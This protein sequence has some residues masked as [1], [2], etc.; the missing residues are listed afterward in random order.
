[1]GAVELLAC[2]LAGF[3]VHCERDAT[4]AAF[5]TIGCG[6]TIALTAYP[7]TPAKLV[8]T[9]RAADKLGVKRCVLGKGS[10]VVASDRHFEGVAIVTCR[11]DGVRV[12]GNHVT[13]RAGASTVRLAN[14]LRE[15][16]LGGGEFL[17][18]LP[19]T[20]GGAV[21]SNAGCFGRDMSSVV[22]CVNVLCGGKVRRLRADKCGF[23]LRDSVFRHNPDWV[24]LDV[25]MEFAPEQ[26][27][28]IAERM[29]QMLRRK[30]AGQPLDRKSAGC[31]LYRQDVAVSRLIDRL[32]LKGCTV[33]GA[34]VSR[35]HAGFVINVDKASGE[36][37][38]LLIQHLQRELWRRYGI[39]ARREVRLLNFT[40]DNDDIFSGS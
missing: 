26:P 25:T 20:V 34:Q 39:V 31:V 10:N 30:A 29:R 18:C 33:G 7:N 40:E 3:G 22:R 32:G 36:D 1:M 27:G 17:A 24:V 4:F 2:R 19:A 12:R 9:V 14:L 6:G 21:I 37:I 28:L 8:Q 38:Y 35:K 5:T 16:G 11:M 15:R 23:A 13:A